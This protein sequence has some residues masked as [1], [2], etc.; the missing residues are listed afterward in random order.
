MRLRRGRAVVRRISDADFRVT[1][2]TLRRTF[3]DRLK[4]VLEIVVQRAAALGKRHADK[5]AES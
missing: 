5:A 4:R 3:D 1:A 2:A